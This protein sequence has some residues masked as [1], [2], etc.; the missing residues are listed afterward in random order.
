[1]DIKE[2][3]LTKKVSE[4]LLNAEI[5][6]VDT[7]KEMSDEQLLTLKGINK[8]ELEEI[9]KKRRL[10]VTP[11]ERR[12]NDLKE[13]RRS[14][15]LIPTPTY[16]LE[17]GDEVELGNLIDVRV[18]EVYDDGKIYEIDYTRVDNNYGNPIKHKNQRMFV[19]WLDIRKKTNNIESFIENRELRLSYFQTSLSSIFSKV[20][21]FGTNLDPVYQRDY[22][23]EL[24]DKVKLIDSIFHHV[25]IGKFVFI[26]LDDYSQNFLYE[27]LDG[28]QRIRAILDYYEDRFEYRGKKFSELSTRDKN[29]FKD[30]PVSFAEVKNSTKEQKLKYFLHLNTGGKVMSKEHIEKV[31]KILEDI[32]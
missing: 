18:V 1:M 15:H 17:I 25:D 23:W 13:I 7:L 6:D 10:V 22:I 16:M 29:H 9:H 30:Y 8:R 27:V 24:E 14:L 5:T 31:K 2:L 3:K 28:K 32:Q 11:K 20:Y 26:N 21:F 12:N 4:I 19:K